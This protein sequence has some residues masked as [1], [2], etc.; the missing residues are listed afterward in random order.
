LGWGWTCIENQ[1]GGPAG[2]DDRH[3][4]HQPEG[5]LVEPGD[6]TIGGRI[7]R[8]NGRQVDCNPKRCREA[9]LHRQ[10][11]PHPDPAGRPECDEARRA[12]AVGIGAIC[13]CLHRPAASSTV[14][15]IFPGRRFAAGS[16][17]TEGSSIELD[18]LLKGHRREVEGEPR[19]RPQNGAKPKRTAGQNTCQPSDFA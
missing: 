17:E 14:M 9:Q 10:I 2:A 16:G 19:K 13:R 5:S 4:G 3:T 1:R 8:K 11:R 6:K 7:E 18:G 12:G 15:T